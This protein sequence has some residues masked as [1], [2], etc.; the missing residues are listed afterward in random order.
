VKLIN[1]KLAHREKIVVCGGACLVGLFLILNLVVFP[2]LSSK[3]KL[4]RSIEVD[5]QRL[6]E[7]V[8]LSAEYEALQGDSGGIGKQLTARGKDFTLFSLLERLATQ[9]GLK[10][11]IKYIK[12]STSQTKGQYQISSV[13]M[14]FEQIT[15]QQLFKYL[16]QVEEP[17]NVVSIKRLSIKKH[18]EQSGYVDATLQVST[19]QPV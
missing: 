1:I 2:V 5:Q 6:K 14:Q 11:R 15:M 3:E 13:E 17:R 8:A 19:V 7:I 9:G 16:H 10:D 12:P 18:K 4:Q